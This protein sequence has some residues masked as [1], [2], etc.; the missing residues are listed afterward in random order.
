[1]KIDFDEFFEGLSETNATLDYFTD[2]T[3]VKANVNLIELKLNQLN[4]LIGK[5]DLKTAVTTLYQECPSVFSV[6]EIL[7]AVRQKE[8]KKTLNTQGQVVTLQSYLTSVDKIVEFIEDTGLADI[9]RDRNIKNL[10]DYVFGIEV[11]LDTNARKNRGGDNMSKAV[12]L[13]FDNA[14]IYYKTEVKNTIFPEIESLGDDVKRFDFVIKTKVKTYV[15]ETNYYNGGG[16]KL[17]EVARAYTDVAPKINQYAQ[18][19]FVWITDGQGWKTAKNKLQEAYRHIPSV[20]N[21]LTLKDFIARVQQE[22]I[23]SDW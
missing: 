15:I 19:E 17:N 8:K 23:L 22:G 5:D 21:L 7:I 9:F 18:Y 3:K 1:M 14:N 2:F 20:Y 10:V 4:Y 12:S 13:L 11:G 6:L 16:S